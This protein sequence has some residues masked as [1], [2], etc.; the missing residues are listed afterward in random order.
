MKKI[1][2][3]V[4]VLIF[5]AISPLYAEDYKEQITKPK[6]KLEEFTARTGTVIVKGFE[7]IGDV[8]GLYDTLIKVD[9]K[10]FFNVSSGKKEYGI[11]IEVIK[12]KGRYDKKDTSYIDYDEIDSLLKGIAYIEKVDNKVTKFSNFQADYNTKGDFSISTF[13]TGNK[14]MIAIS[15]RRIGGVSAYYNFSSLTE[16]K[17]LIQKAKQKIDSIRQ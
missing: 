2:G 4:S 16:I 14:I 1:T 10:E 17:S 7:E 11:T 6:T 15:S 9:A 3:L 8:Y 5:V 12:E 13:S